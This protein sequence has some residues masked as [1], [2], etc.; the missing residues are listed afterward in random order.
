MPEALAKHVIN[1]ISCDNSGLSSQK[2][3]LQSP[4]TEGW[5]QFWE[6]SPV[7]PF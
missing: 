5:L 2:M 4:I 1:T 7:S 6:G 3:K